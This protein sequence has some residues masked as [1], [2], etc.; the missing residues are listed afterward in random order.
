MSAKTYLAPG[1]KLKIQVPNALSGEL[2]QFFPEGIGCF[3]KKHLI[4]TLKLARWRQNHQ[5]TDLAFLFG[6]AQIDQQ[7]CN[8][9]ETGE[10]SS[11]SVDS[12]LTDDHSGRLPSHLRKSAIRF[13]F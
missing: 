12:A 8:Q 11:S 1:Q 13:F 5:L 7:S 3:R 4:G 9:F 6:E 2:V 10:G